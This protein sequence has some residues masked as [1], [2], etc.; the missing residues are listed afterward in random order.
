MM[1]IDGVATITTAV[2]PNF[3]PSSLLLL[4]AFSTHLPQDASTNAMMFWRW[5]HIAASILWIG[6]LYYFN[7]VNM[8]FLRELDPSVR[9]RIFAPLMLRAMNWFRW[10]SLVTVLAGLALWGQIV[11]SDA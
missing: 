5:L 2:L 1:N 7:L 10:S 9:S 4:G 8:P 6:L 3:H 11:N